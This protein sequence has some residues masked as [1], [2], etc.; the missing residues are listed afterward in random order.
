MATTKH[1]I[2]IREPFFLNLIINTSG[3]GGAISVRRR[4]GILSSA[5]M[6]QYYFNPLKPKSM[7]RA[8]RKGIK[9]VN[10]RQQK[11][12]TTQENARAIL[13]LAEDLFKDL[14]GE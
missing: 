9:N 5:Y 12:C 10:H 7:I 4:T 2:Y 1:E 6:T 3:Q 13:E 8:L 14:Q 11:F